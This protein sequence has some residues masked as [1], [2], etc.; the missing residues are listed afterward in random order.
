M[1][2]WYEIH[3][4]LVLSQTKILSRKIKL[5]IF[6]LF[7]QK[8][9]TLSSAIIKNREDI[10][11]HSL[12]TTSMKWISYQ[13]S[14]S[15]NELYLFNRGNFRKGKRERKQEREKIEINFFTKVKSCLRN[16]TF[17]CNFFYILITLVPSI[18]SL[19]GLEQS[20]ILQYSILVR[21]P[22]HD[23]P[24]FW[25][26]TSFVLSKFWVPLPHDL[27]HLP[28]FDQSDHWQST[29]NSNS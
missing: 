9:K 14:T 20:W 13:I 6:S 24:P 15:Y 16:Y 21:L 18:L 28:V 25:D 4:M 11:F 2:I 7:L 27:L 23:W 22:V 5:W 10:I 19:P 12:E 8:L 1:L 3:F 17:K 29:E 26:S